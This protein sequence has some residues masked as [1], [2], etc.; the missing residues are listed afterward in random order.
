LL[1]NG[2]KVEFHK[3]RLVRN[4]RLQIDMILP[5]HNIAIEIDGPSHIR[6]VWGEENFERNKR[7]DDQK[8]GLLLGLGFTL[9]R[10]L[11]DSTLSNVRKNAYLNEL[12]KVVES[13]VDKTETSKY[14][15]IGDVN[16]KN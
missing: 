12:L 8:T 4:E 2:Y 10:L 1:K 6:P 14:I 5:E 16:G 11:Q 9:I 13:V 7:S 15:K 3:E